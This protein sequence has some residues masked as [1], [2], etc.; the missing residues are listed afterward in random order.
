MRQK[1]RVRNRGAARRKIARSVVD[2]VLGEAAFQAT[3]EERFQ[4]MRAIASVIMNRARRL[5]VTPEEVV[6]AVKGANKQFDAY[7]TRLPE[8][9]EEYRKLAE[10]ALEDVKRAGPITGA[11]Y[12]AT[13]A[14]LAGLLEGNPQF[15]R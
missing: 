5:Q 6:S 1:D 10:L 12:Y 9:A 14:A 3:P 15:R 13:P 11:I 7:N 8:G 2:V 4:D